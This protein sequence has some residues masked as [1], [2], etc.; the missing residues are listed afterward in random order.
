MTNYILLKVSYS[1]F[2][3]MD[4]S[5]SFR[6]GTVLAS[7][8]LPAAEVARNGRPCQSIPRRRTKLSSRTSNFNNCLVFVPSLF[9]T[10]QLGRPVLKNNRRSRLSAHKPFDSSGTAACYH[11]NST[12]RSVQMRQL[13]FPHCLSRI[14]FFGA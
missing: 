7:T 2:P 10:V 5:E 12:L 11:W 9:I 6:P 3:Q 13:I 1:K 8:I 4:V 14:E